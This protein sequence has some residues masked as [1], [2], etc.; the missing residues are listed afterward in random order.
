ME[1]YHWDLANSTKMGEYLTR[2]EQKSITQFLKNNNVGICLDVACGSGR[3]SIPISRHGVKVVA[4][5]RNLVPLKKLKD[6]LGDEEQIAV[7]RGD[8]NKLPFKES[9][10]D[11]IVSIETADYLDVLNFFAG[12]NKILRKDGYLL[13]TSAN[14]HSYK[15]YITSILSNDMI[16][17][18]YSFND[19][20]ACLQKNSFSL[21]ICNGYNWIPFKRNS[22]SFLIDSFEF[23]EKMLKLDLRASISPWVFFVAKKEK[24]LNEEG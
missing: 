11:C 4:V 7:I 22:N 6:K 23:L 16:F 5:D 17:Y 19:I 1:E 14:N 3:F 10:F 20:C 24:R 21:K 18:R 13:V 8:A 15:K 12:C 9:T 2:R